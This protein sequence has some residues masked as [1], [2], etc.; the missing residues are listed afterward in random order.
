M[1][2][3][4]GRTQTKEEIPDSPL[5]VDA[6]LVCTG[7]RRRRGEGERH[8]RGGERAGR[9]RRRRRRRMRRRL[10][11]SQVV[12]PTRRPW[13]LRTWGSRQFEGLCR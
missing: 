7:E 12:S 4:D 6:A 1:W 9:R 3:G 10:T 11:T 2:W 13:G 5:Y 8:G